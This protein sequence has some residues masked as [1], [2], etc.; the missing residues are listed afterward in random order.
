MQLKYFGNLIPPV[1]GMQKISSIAW[2]PNGSKL[3]VCTAE[4]VNNH[5]CLINLLRIIGG[6]F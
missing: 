5:I 1:D 4:R 3:A 2:A 6:G